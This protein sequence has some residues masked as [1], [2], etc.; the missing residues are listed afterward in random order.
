MELTIDNQKYVNTYVM[1]C[2]GYFYLEH[3][4]RIYG[5]WKNNNGASYLHDTWLWHLIQ[6]TQQELY[7]WKSPS[8]GDIER[9]ID[10]LNKS[11]FA[12]A[13]VFVKTMLES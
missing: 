12:D 3:K 5:F 4:G 9:V 10:L 2:P 13:E 8:C 11:K 7:P 1:T 6:G